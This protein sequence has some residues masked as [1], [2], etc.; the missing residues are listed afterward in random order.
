MT[1]TA[2]LFHEPTEFPTFAVLSLGIASL[3]DALDKVLDIDFLHCLS[4]KSWYYLREIFLIIKGGG[5]V[6]SSFEWALLLIR[7]RG[8]HLNEEVDDKRET[9]IWLLVLSE[10]CELQWDRGL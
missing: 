4:L 7:R 10:R 2:I 8:I 9:P 5:D 3:E 1:P 6:S